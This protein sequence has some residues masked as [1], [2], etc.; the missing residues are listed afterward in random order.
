MAGYLE[1][2]FEIQKSSSVGNLQNFLS[3]SSDPYWGLSLIKSQSTLLEWAEVIVSIVLLELAL[4]KTFWEAIFGLYSL[5]LTQV[6]AN[7]RHART[8]HRTEARI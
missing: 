8:M 1:I 6:P 7:R 2:E 3:I 5:L 4:P